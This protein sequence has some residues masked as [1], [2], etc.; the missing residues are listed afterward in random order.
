[1]FSEREPGVY[2]SGDRILVG[3]ASR[4][5][6]A[7]DVT[8]TSYQINDSAD[9][10]N[11]PLAVSDLPSGVK[12]SHYEIS[13]TFT[14]R[15]ETTGGESLFVRVYDNGAG[16]AFTDTEIEVTATS[17]TTVQT[18]SETVSPPVQTDLRLQERVSG[19]SGRVFGNVS[20]NVYAVVA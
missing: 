13:A 10:G 17:A 3:T 12:I 16:A 15:A 20:F 2:Q 14:G 6:G 9:G 4:G 7:Y 5:S 8:N 1:M 19:G 18:N 11:A